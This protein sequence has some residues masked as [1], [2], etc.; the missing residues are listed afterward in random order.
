MQYG[1][2]AGVEATPIY[3]K[4]AF[5]EGHM[6]YFSV[7]LN[8]GVGAGDTRVQL[9]PSSTSGPSTFG[10]TGWRFLGNVGGGFRVKLGEHVAIRLEIRDLVYSASVSSIDGCNENDLEQI[11]SNGSPTSASCAAKNFTDP[12]GDPVLA[13]ALLKTPSSDVLNQVTAFAGLAYIF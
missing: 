4:V 11:T 13:K 1:G 8:A 12:Q 7:V 6:A 2:E 10:D 9:R 3:G 5:Y